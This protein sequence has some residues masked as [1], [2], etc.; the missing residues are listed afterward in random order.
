MNCP[1][2]YNAHI[3]M[4]TPCEGN[5]CGWWDE[6]HEMC[7]VLLSSWRLEDVK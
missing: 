4:N 7:S 5:T 2:K 3:C 6:E 1:L